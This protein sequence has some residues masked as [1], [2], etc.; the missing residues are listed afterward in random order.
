[1]SD[2]AAA[3]VPAGW[4]PDPQD[5]SRGRFWDG[6]AWTDQYHHAGQP[7]PIAQL[8]APPGTDWNTPWIWVIVLIPVV[9]YIPLLFLPW[10]VLSHIDP[11]SP[12]SIIQAEFD[13][14]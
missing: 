12:A 7:L 4:Y 5:A 3:P 13:L 6:T 11:N 2:Q 14:L 1:M 10:H 8:K 9:T